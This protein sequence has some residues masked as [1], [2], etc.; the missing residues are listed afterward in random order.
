MYFK[1]TGA[2]IWLAILIVFGLLKNAVCITCPINN[3]FTL[4]TSLL[5]GSRPQ[6]LFIDPWL[7]SD[8]HSTPWLFIDPLDGP[9]DTWGRYGPLW[10]PLV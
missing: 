7:F 1:T 9:I 8:P 6:Q 2:E 3:N 5:H 4:E 10:E